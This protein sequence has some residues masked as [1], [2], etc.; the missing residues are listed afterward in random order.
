MDIQQDGSRL[1]IQHRHR[2]SMLVILM[3][4]LFLAALLFAFSMTV[5]MVWEMPYTYPSPVRTVF[6][7]LWLL[8]WTALAVVVLL[9]LMWESLGREVI[10]F[11]DERLRI[12]R[13]VGRIT[14]PR[15][16]D[17][18]RVTDLRT[19]SAVSNPVKRFLS[20]F[21]PRVSLLTAMDVFFGRGSGT[22]SFVYHHK[23]YRFGYKM[24]GPDVDVILG[25]VA[26]K[27][28]KNIENI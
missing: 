15:T 25:R 5:G 11:T 27:Y 13:H 17:L 12:E 28:R 4:V 20:L 21:K 22:F 3:D 23:E 6:L 19:G 24:S 7:V 1:I 2:P 10:L 26:A 14:Y 8:V 16:F 9:S 18:S